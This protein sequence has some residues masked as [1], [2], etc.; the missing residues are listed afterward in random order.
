MIRS[1]PAAIGIGAPIL[2]GRAFSRGPKRKIPPADWRDDGE[3]KPGVRRTAPGEWPERLRFCCP[4][5][6]VRAQRFRA[7]VCRSDGVGQPCHCSSFALPSACAAKTAQQKTLEAGPTRVRMNTRRGHASRST[8]D[9]M[10]QCNT[11][12]M[13]SCSCAGG[14]TECGQIQ[15]AEP[16][17]SQ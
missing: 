11:I 3:I 17:M 2:C 10:R 12:H 1:N 5:C 7:H 4:C 6:F 15:G 16:S 9:A 13:R 8:R 14:N